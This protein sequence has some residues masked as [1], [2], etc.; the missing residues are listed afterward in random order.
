MKIKQLV[1][2]YFPQERMLGDAL[3]ERS[4]IDFD[5]YFWKAIFQ[6]DSEILDDIISIGLFNLKSSVDIEL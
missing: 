2:V 6:K 4:D 5:E 1:F 3:I